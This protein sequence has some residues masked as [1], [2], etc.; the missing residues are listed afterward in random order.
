MRAKFAGDWDAAAAY[1]RPLVEFVSAVEPPKERGGS[2]LLDVGCGVGWSTHEFARG[3][4]QAT[5]IDLDPSAFEA[6]PRPR[7]ALR[8]GAATAI[9][10]P[11]G[12]FDCVV[13]YQCLE[14]VPDPA[15]ALLEM[16]RV[17]RPGGVVAVVGPNLVTPVPG[18][19]RLA[20]PRSWRGLRL[21]RRPGMPRHPFGNTLVEV[22]GFAG[23]RGLQ[24]AGKLLARTPRLLMRTPDRRPPYHADND[25]CYLCCPTD[26]IRHFRALGWRIERRGKPGRWGLVHL[27]AGGTWVVARKPL[28]TA[29][30][31]DLARA[32]L[33]LDLEDRS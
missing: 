33:S 1:Y 2:T 25:A 10:F 22:L 12:S 16:A 7:M 32:A 23:L 20:R 26:L 24:L 19:L 4:Y 18:L 30:P 13:C 28:Q 8:R 29:D 3:G 5:G 6:P 21:R 9:P 11:S 17:C 15:G 14:H 27:L 31:A